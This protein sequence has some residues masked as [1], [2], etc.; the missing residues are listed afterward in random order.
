MTERT[1]NVN[2]RANIADY[3]AKMKGSSA[4]TRDAEKA[5]RDLRRALDEE[6]AS[7]GRVR[8]AE[9]KLNEVRSSGKA[10]ASQ[11]AAA[12]EDLSRAHRQHESAVERVTLANRK[13]VESQKAAAGESERSSKKVDDQM[14][15]LAAR[16]NAQFDAL[17]FTGLSVGLPA[18]AAVGAAG[19]GAILSGTAAG[20]AA[21]GIYAISSSDDVQSA[22]KDMANH[23][24]D[25][26]NHMGAGIQGDVI[27]AL[28]NAGNAWDRLEP[29][30][31]AAVDGSGAAVR[32][33]SGSV[34]DFAENAMPGM[35]VAVRESEAPLKGVHSL[36]AQAG[37]GLSEF[38]INA[39][40]GA[41]GARQGLVIFGGSI[42]LLEA[43]LG[44]LLANFATGSA[45]PLSSFHVIIDEVTGGLV[46]MT[47]EGS[48]VIGFLSGFTNTGTGTVSML[49]LLLS[50]VSMLPAEVGQVTGS[51]AAGS[52]IASKFGIDVRDGFRGM[53]QE[54]KNAEGIRGKFVTGLGSLAAGFTPATV[55]VG[56]FSMLLGLIGQ[57][58]A[59][60]AQR[61]A[62]HTQAIEDMTEAYRRD[63]GVI[64]E[65][66]R[67]TALKAL[68]DKNA[69]LSNDRLGVSMATVSAA[70][71]G[72]GDA[73]RTVNDNFRGYLTRL[74]QAHQVGGDVTDMV[75]RQ[76]DA[77]VKQGGSAA[78]VVDKMTATRMASLDL[79]DAQKAELVTTLQNVRAINQQADASDAGAKKAAELESGLRL[80][81][82][83]TARGMTPAMIAAQASVA[84]LQTAFEA[85]NNA[86]GDVASKG[87]AIID[88][89]RE[90]AGQTP[91]V[92]DALQKWNDDLRGIKDGFEKLDLKKHSKDIVDSSG[93]INTAS[94]AGSKLKSTIEQQTNDFAAYAQSLREA[95]TP[96]NDIPPKL[97]AMRDAFA[98]Q[99]HQLGLTD[100]QIGRVLD[101]YGMVPA[102]V[103]TKLGL[104]GDTQ[105][106]AQLTDVM[107]KLAAVPAEKGIVMDALTDPAIAALGELGDT[108][109][110]MPNGK[111]AVFANTEPGRKAAQDLLD[112]VGN[113]NA[114]A[115][116]FANTSP[117]DGAVTDWKNVT[118]QTVGNTTTYTTVDPATGMVRQ[119][120]ATTDA[121]GA[122]THTYADINPA[123]G[124]VRVWKQN[125]DG[126][127][128]EVHAKADVAA[129]ESQL[130]NAARTRTATIRGVYIAPST[131]GLGAAANRL[132]KGG[133]VGYA[134][135]GA[136]ESVP[137]LA[138]G[139]VRPIVPLDIRGGGKLHG[140]GTGTSDS[141]VAMS[142]RGPVRVANREF[143]VNAQDTAIAEPLLRFINAGGLR[144]FANGGPVEYGSVPQSTWDSLYAAGWRG[145]PTDGREALYPP[146]STAQSRVQQAIA[147]GAAVQYAP[148]GASG[149]M[150]YR[151]EF[152]RGSGQIE[153]ALIGWLK[154]TVRKS[155]GD[156]QKAFT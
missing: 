151:F 70:A 28:G 19:V 29:H 142:S 10:S 84:D 26:V 27:D 90:M 138:A 92:E 98:G 46:D 39:S 37:D 66:V 115:T 109:V 65:N 117:A 56:V 114:T 8:V 137:R 79:T 77:Y 104:E 124:Q 43:R 140:P 11:L 57:K 69:F 143:V 9:A 12:E 3:V 1:V 4:A 110:K 42:A 30:V 32:E 45:G 123:N 76:A 153:R 97:N 17:K 141:I 5:A 111:F 14:S 128:A 120:K 101:H 155:G 73:V 75:L 6:E 89:M 102:K 49:R 48:S 64:G 96:L 132:A 38:F 58:Q 15:R 105:T 83:I 7:A 52:M 131:S 53:G 94:E 88:V 150:T 80:V 25:D 71:L 67:Q 107:T 34:T 148:R 106:Q 40:A 2:L 13:F 103:I 100:D 24:L 87:K 147:S 91:S 21:L 20:F 78:D 47:H 156:V 51:L 118:S 129:A 16:T 68:S 122:V 61:A 50:L 82:S 63:N 95:G 136:I 152:G 36:A 60:A 144:R 149:Q 112:K 127:W 44:T 85:L 81:E 126:T 33:L 133:L 55:A 93:A 62:Q 31:R 119:W 18:A 108:V 146:Q 116:V 35:V 154:D 74:V 41:E 59:E 125:A 22:A 121:T 86:G 23:V 134:R 130:N 54:I 135:G 139:G 113:T 99:L 72:Q 145:D